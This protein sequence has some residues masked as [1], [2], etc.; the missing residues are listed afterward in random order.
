[1][2]KQYAF[3]IFPILIFSFLQFNS[4]SNF[5]DITNQHVF[6]CECEQWKT[7]T[8]SLL[9]SVTEPEASFS[10]YDYSGELEA[11]AGCH[12]EMTLS[13]RWTDA[14]L[15][16]TDE[17][18]PLDYEFQSLFGYFPTNPGMENMHYDSE[19]EANIWTIS[20][21]EADDASNPEGTSYGVFVRYLTGKSKG[22][23]TIMCSVE[24]RYKVYNEY[25]YTDGCDLK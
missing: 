2:K 3:L 5:E 14:E 20:I 12:A 17:R 11:D 7:A 10:T 13:F 6:G 22:Y 23:T 24:I 9:V 18:P 25:A 1:M 4:C 16:Q 8:S 15:A 19:Q 21:S